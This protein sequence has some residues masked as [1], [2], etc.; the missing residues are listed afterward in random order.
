MANKRTVPKLKMGWLFILPWIVDNIGGVN[1]VVLELCT[2]CGKEKEYLPYLATPTNQVY[3]ELP[4]LNHVFQSVVFK[5]LILSLDTSNNI[6]H[7]LFFL[8]RLPYEIVKSGWV[9]KKLNIKTVNFH[10]V[11][12]LSPLTFAMIKMF[13]PLKFRM[14]LSFHGS[15][16]LSLEK[17]S[18]LEKKIFGFILSKT[19]YAVGCSKGIS[20]QI[21]AIFPKYEKK[22]V[23]VHNGI[24]EHFFFSKFENFKKKE[25]ADGIQGKKF[26]L[27]IGAFIHIKGH[28]ILIK[29]F[30]ILKKSHPDLFL[31][32]VGKPAVE[33]KKIK[34]L[35][36]SLELDKSIYIYDMVLP[37]QITKFYDN[38]S[39]F[40]SASRYE[41]FG[42][43]IAEAG[44]RGLPVIATKTI[45]SE[46]I[47]EHSISGLLVE[48]ENPE[49]LEKAI[50]FLLNNPERA[51][52][53]AENMRR[54]VSSHF[55]WEFAWEKYK[56]LALN[57]WPE[58][59]ESGIKSEE[60]S[61]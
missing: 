50:R 7:I 49:A 10:Y 32:I 46:E 3:K 61:L 54:R 8:L 43:V 2:Y 5:P 13:F 34:Q 53:F 37:D 11:G 19:D 40:V 41:S 36:D 55:R 17:C 58:N 31:I 26:I 23:F 9:V 15:D 12:G 60:R 47:I 51:H 48:K 33:S 44:A 1:R 59:S 30:S 56:L 45:G 21:K 57:Q 52:F 28:D 29:A 14:I 22:I 27:S 25:F 42:L 6:K 35:I 20:C 4:M 24:S 18:K 16:V 38:A 39:L